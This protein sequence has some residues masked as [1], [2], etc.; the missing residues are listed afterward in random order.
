MLEEKQNCDQTRAT[1]I[2][3]YRKGKD[4]TLV[5]KSLQFA[6]IFFLLK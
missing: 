6:V 1:I 5:S 2:V 4:K 3:Q